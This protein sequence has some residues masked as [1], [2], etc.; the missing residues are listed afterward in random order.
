MPSMQLWVV[1]VW[2]VQHFLL[3]VRYSF[4]VAF[5]KGE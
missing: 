3:G 5:E 1:Q 2:S 4:L